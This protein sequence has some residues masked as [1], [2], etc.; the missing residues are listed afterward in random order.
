MENVTVVVARHEDSRN[1]I[2]CSSVYSQLRL[3]KNEPR[4]S[5][6]Y[7]MA[8]THPLAFSPENLWQNQD[9]QSDFAALIVEQSAV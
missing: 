3:S 4:L 9:A 8:S 7:V 6:R 5:T 1:P 2:C